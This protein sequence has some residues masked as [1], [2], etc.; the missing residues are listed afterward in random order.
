MTEDDMVGWRAPLQP[1]AEGCLGAMSPPQPSAPPT[2]R[3]SAFSSHDVTPRAFS[4]E[5]LPALN[6]LPPKTSTA[7]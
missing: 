4:E 6:A 7:P 3:A 2:V 5:L 1:Q